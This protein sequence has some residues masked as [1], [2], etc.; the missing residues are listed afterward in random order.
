[1]GWSKLTQNVVLRIPELY[2]GKAQQLCVP[3]TPVV[4]GGTGS[5]TNS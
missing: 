2:N 1:M 4:C 3:T 5:S